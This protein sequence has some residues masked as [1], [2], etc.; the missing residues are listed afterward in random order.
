[1]SKMIPPFYDAE[2]TS[3][4]EK[5]IFDVLQKLDDDYTILHSLG[6]AHH[7]E[8]VFGEI[9]FLIIC[10]QGILCLEVKGGHVSRSEGVWYFTDRYGAET[11]KTEG[12]FRQVFSAMLSLR[13]HMKKQFGTNDP[14]ANC[15]FAC[16][17][18]FPDMPFTQTGPDIINEIVFD[19]RKPYE[20]FES[21][22]TGVFS[23]WRN[24]LESKYGFTGGYLSPTQVSKAVNYLRGDFGFVPS[25]GYIVEKTEEKLLALTK[26]QADRLA[27]AAENP[28]IV[29]KGG[30]GTGKTILSL[31][32]ARRRALVGK[33][34]L[35]LCFNHNLGNHLKNV[36]QKTCPQPEGNLTIET[37]HGYIIKELNEHGYMPPVSAER[38]EEFYSHVVPEIFLEMTKQPWYERR[39]DTLVIDEGQDLLGLENLMCLDAMLDGGLKHGNWHL[40]Y[41]P[42]QN[43]Y[44]S[45]FDTG[46]SLLMEYHPTL[47]GLDTNCRNT[48]PVGIYNTLFTGMKPARFFR[49][50]GENVVKE[51]YNDFSDERKKILKTV[52][53]LIGQ[54]IKPGSICLLSRFKYENSCLQGENIFKDVARFQN[55]TNLDPRYIVDDSIKFC[56]IHSFKGLEAPVVLLID[57]EGFR[58][59]VAR[60]L[61]YTG[62]SRATSLLYVFYNRKCENE[63]QEMVNNSAE[64]LQFIE[65]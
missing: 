62:M 56:T 40:C 41:D 28:R 29:L 50:D 37:F 65:Y 54:G 8:K 36:I 27:I 52:K 1:M 25:L 39:Y 17:V 47:L 5:K 24:R 33:K 19:A 60:H 21:Y 22:I 48:R 58:D 30:A 14:V 38:N 2:I 16:G 18:F 45:E 13:D 46:I 10:R 34:V 42:N 44:N 61:N 51:A 64:L 53:R 4:G 6:I 35:F 63:L 3:D 57:V 59:P 15:Q 23:Y 9:D 55:I 12:P 32:Y 43:I 20:E 31:E 26:E 7:R 49:V 11:R